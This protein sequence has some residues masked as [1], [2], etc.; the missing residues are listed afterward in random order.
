MQELRRGLAQA[1]SRTRR[2]NSWPREE[3]RAAQ[4][5][6]RRAGTLACLYDA[7]MVV[8]CLFNSGCGFG[9]HGM[10]VLEICRDR[11]A[12][13]RW[14]LRKGRRAVLREDC[15]RYIFGRTR[16]LAGT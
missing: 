11:L 9:R 3:L 6:R 5:Q 7:D 12:L 14:D 10:T 16:L 1:P 13:V 4:L 2:A 15:L 8:P